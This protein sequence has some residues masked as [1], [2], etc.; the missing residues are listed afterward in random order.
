MHG[1]GTPWTRNETIE[2]HMCPDCKG[3]MKIYT[4][5]GKLKV[6]CS[7]CAPEGVACDRCLPPGH[8]S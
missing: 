8:G 1:K 4:E 5:D 6:Q 2:R 7:K 3:D